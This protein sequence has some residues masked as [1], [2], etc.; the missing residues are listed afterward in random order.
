MAKI[1]ASALIIFGVINLINEYFPAFPIKLK[2]PNAA[3]AKIADLM[4]TASLPAALGLG[5]LVGLCEFPCT[6]GPYLTAIGLLHDSATFLKGFGYLIIYNILFILPLVLILSI[7]GNNATL[8][9]IQQ[10]K[11][12]NLKRVKIWIGFI[13]VA[14]GI[15][16]FLM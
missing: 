9:K 4:E 14:L 1:G 3:H 15:I 16:I 12:Q 13:M 11:S 6:G 10:W 2:I 5:I 8:S 7:A